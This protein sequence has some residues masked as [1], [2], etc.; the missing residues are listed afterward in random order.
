MATWNAFAESAPELAELGLKLLNQYGAAFLATVRRDGSPRLHPV[1][2]IVTE[3]KLFVFCGGPK[4]HDLRRDGRYNL[5]ALIDRDD[6]EFLVA[7]RAVYVNDD[8]TIRAAVARAAPYKVPVDPADLTHLLFHF[9]IERACDCVVS[10]WPAGHS[11]YSH[12]LVRA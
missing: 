5:N 1:V 9:D 7:G 11:A 2:P 8:R 6:T 3:G 10:P 4:V 12:R